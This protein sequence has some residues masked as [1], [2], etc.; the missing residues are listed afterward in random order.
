MSVMTLTPTS[1]KPFHTEAASV[2]RRLRTALTEVI[3][4]IPGQ[5]ETATDLERA[6]GVRKT[7]AWRIFRIA[8]SPE[9]LAEWNKLPGQSA[10]K[11]F[12]KAAAKV[13]V[14]KRHIDS[15]LA[16]FNEYGQVIKTH[17]GD[18]A[19][20]DAM[21][22][23]LSGSEESPVDEQN[24]RAT[25]LGNSHI[26]GVQ[27]RTRLSCAMLVPCT[28][29]GERA[30]AV[31]IRGFVDLRWLR[32]EHSPVL[33]SRAGVVDL[34]DSKCVHDFDSLQIG[35]SESGQPG[36]GLIK[37]FCS[38]PLPKLHATKGID[39]VV[40]TMLV[41]DHVGNRS[42]CTCI[43]ASVYRGVGK[44][45]YTK[46]DPTNSW[47][48]LVR[49]PVQVLVHDVLMH[50]MYVASE[51]TI[52]VYADHQACEGNVPIS[53][54]SVRLPQKVTARYLGNAADVLETRDVP[55]YPEMAEYVAGKLRIDLHSLRVYRCRIEYPFMPSSVVMRFEAPEK[56]GK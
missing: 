36:E 38:Q 6:L 29:D 11:G 35:S 24:R 19:T 31:T 20:F 33:L 43:A 17:A 27:A 45:F 47:A 5:V 8:R 25:F 44:L 13:G 2:M 46:Q 26:L 7:I 54:T 12:F 49:L 23:G 21:I 55:R 30:D 9:P 40:K 39:G 4:G 42:M 41:S 56:P 52:E 37:E 15:A 16:A 32:A 34:E 1:T 51:P 22:S 50:E 53:D 18:R 48:A 10:M 28:P 14:P 3:A